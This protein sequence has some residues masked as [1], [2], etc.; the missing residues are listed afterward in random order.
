MHRPNSAVAVTG[1]L[2]VVAAAFFSVFICFFGVQA[3]QVLL[4]ERLAESSQVVTNLV[5]LSKLLDSTPRVIVGVRLDVLVCSASRAEI[6][7]AAV[8]DKTGS[9]MLELG[10]RGKPVRGR[11]VIHIEGRR[12]LLRQREMGVE[13]TRVP[14]IYNDGM[15]GIQK[16]AAEVVLRQASTLFNWTTSIILPPM[17]WNCPADC[18]MARFSRPVVFWSGP[19]AVGCPNP[20]W[21]PGWRR[22]VTRMAGCYVPDYALLQPVKTVATTNLNP[23][24]GLKNEQFGI[25]FKGYFSAPMDGKL[26]V[27][28]GI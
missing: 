4:P 23:N 10:P 6:G 2:R 14:D 24:L 17:A 26:C 20:T 13:I 22:L 19:A 25:R 27:R 7:V 1:I 8:M 9:G 12:C 3:Q 11:D 5:Q 28:P 21:L 15:H 18:P 16:V